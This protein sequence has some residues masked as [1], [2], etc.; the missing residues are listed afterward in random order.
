MAPKAIV[1][2]DDATPRLFA[3]DT[4]AVVAALIDT[5]PKH[6]VYRDFVTGAIENS[7]TFIFSELLDVELA[8]VC[9]KNSRSEKHR[10]TKRMLE[11]RNDTLDRVMGAWEDVLEL[12]DHTRLPIRESHD[13]QGWE[14]AYALAIDLLRSY[15]IRINDAI[16]AA[17]A[18]ILSV[19][20]LTDDDDFARIPRLSIVTEPGKVAAMNAKRR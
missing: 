19:P 18:I 15:P 3:L 10:S 5:Q 13:A 14:H 6:D 7:S 16:H 9:E 17:T 2:T 12:V 11:S 4:S 1:S 20:L 8:G